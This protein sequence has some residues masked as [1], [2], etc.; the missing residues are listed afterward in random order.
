MVLNSHACNCWT[1]SW[2]LRLFCILS[3]I[4]EKEKLDTVSV[5]LCCGLDIDWCHALSDVTLF[6]KSNSP[7][8]TFY[9][10]TDRG[11]NFQSSLLSKDKQQVRPLTHFETKIGFIITVIYIIIKIIYNI[12]KIILLSVNIAP[13]FGYSVSVFYS[14]LWRQILEHMGKALAHVLSHLLAFKLITYTVEWRLL[15]GLSCSLVI[16]SYIYSPASGE[17]DLALCNRRT[18][19]AIL[20][21]SYLVVFMPQINRLATQPLFL[22]R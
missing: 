21:T 12:Y 18:K 4:G 3:G 19:A 8:T 7:I 14:N 9:Y 10:S 22:F 20:H 6:Y 11:R 17:A 5:H 2:L 16:D 13:W 1:G 15:I